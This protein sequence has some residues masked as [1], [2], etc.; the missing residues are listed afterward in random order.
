M[1]NNI[2]KVEGKSIIKLIIDK[3]YV[4]FAR[5]LAASKGVEIDNIIQDLIKE[6]F[7]KVAGKL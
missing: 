1:T 6:K 5:L 4:K 2:K 7:G 3:K